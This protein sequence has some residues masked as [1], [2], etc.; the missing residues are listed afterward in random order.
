MA[1]SRCLNFASASIERPGIFTSCQRGDP[2]FTV[3]CFVANN[4][5]FAL[6][7]LGHALRSCVFL[8]Q[9]TFAFSS[10][11][12][13]PSR[14]FLFALICNVS[15]PFRRPLCPP[16][17]RVDVD[18]LTLLAGSPAFFKEIRNDQERQT[19]EPANF[20]SSVP[21]KSASSCLPELRNP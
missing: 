21:T 4:T 1:C 5:C 11:T 3:V 8:M 12:C 16:L 13:S 20:P 17:C 14:S 19:K 9:A 7:C 18:C 15:R 10:A 6:H 2:V